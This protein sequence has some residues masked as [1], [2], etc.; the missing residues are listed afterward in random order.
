MPDS[1]EPANDRDEPLIVRT[2]VTPWG[3]LL[4]LT[5]ALALAALG[6]RLIDAGE[7]HELLAGLDARSTSALGM[8]L[9]GFS[10]YLFLVGVG[11]LAA[12][13]KPTVDLVM[14]TDGVSVFG[15]LG[16]RRLAWQDL[17]RADIQGDDLVLLAR[18]RTRRG[19][20][21]VRLPLNRLAADPKE[22]LKRLQQHR[23]DLPMILRP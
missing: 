4:A 3:F 11:E 5:F 22:L 1:E 20:R 10:L 21:S 14:D 16:E 23:P 7:A 8:L 9:I 6:A 2:H 15:L 13:L 18:S 12:Y 17:V 19:G